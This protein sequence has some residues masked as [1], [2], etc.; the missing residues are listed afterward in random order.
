VTFVCEYVNEFLNCNEI[1]G[2]LDEIKNC[3]FFEVYLIPRSRPDSV[4]VIH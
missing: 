1:M 4:L 2:F 3:E